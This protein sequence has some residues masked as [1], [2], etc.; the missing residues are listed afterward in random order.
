[1]IGFKLENIHD[2]A[3]IRTKEAKEGFPP[4]PLITFQATAFL[5]LARATR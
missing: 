5:R 1:V 3:E 2:D 4:N